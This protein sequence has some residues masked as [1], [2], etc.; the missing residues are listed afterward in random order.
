MMFFYRILNVLTPTLTGFKQ[1]VKTEWK[2]QAFAVIEEYKER[3][4]EIKNFRGGPKKKKSIPNC[5]PASDSSDSSSDD[6]SDNEV[7]INLKR[8]FKE[9]KEESDSDD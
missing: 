3:V 1:H 7:L 6:E 9:Q 8:Q 2:N 4:G 5:P